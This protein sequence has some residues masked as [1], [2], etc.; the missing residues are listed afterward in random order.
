MTADPSLPTAEEFSEDFASLLEA[1]SNTSER[2]QPGQRVKGV[3]IAITGDSV[4][5][6]VGIKVDGIMDRKDILDAEGNPTAAVGDT[7]EAWVIACTPQ[8]VR[9]SRSMSGSGM[10]ALEDARDNAIPVDGRVTGTCKGGYTVEVLGKS[11]FCPGSQMDMA[12]QADPEAVVGLSY[13][14][15]ILRVENHGR[16]IV[17]SRRAL[18]DREREENLATLLSTLKEGDIVEGTVS[19][20]APFGAF[21]TLQPGV[22]GMIHLSELSWSR[23]GTADEA[24]NPGDTIR[25]KVLGI[26][27]DA[28]GRTRISLSRKQAQEDPWAS[29]AETLHTGDLVTGRVVRLAPFGAFV[30]VLPGV[31][32]LVH[33]S[34][35]SWTKRVHKAEDLLK[36][37]ESVSVKIKECIPERRRLSLS[38][39]DAEGDPWSLVPERLPAGSTVT[40]TVESKAPFGIFVSLLPGVTGLLPNAALKNVPPSSALHKLD[41]GDSVSLKIQSVDMAARRISLIPEDSE[42]TRDSSWRQHAPAPASQGFGSLG[43]A[44]QAALRQ[45]K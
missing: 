24:V 25:A 18:V 21:V 17:V 43:M 27:Q 6:D 3:I 8:E 44:L 1:H 37:G 16:N 2:L 29:A 5:L 38:L 32:G 22:E 30:E 41:K 33:L 28:K 19:R 34:E 20:L 12:A 42:D 13:Q 23:V 10:A 4:F 15:L 14:F 39:R 31:E 9:L 26:S 35:L 40:G 11:A 45:K 7:V 36:V